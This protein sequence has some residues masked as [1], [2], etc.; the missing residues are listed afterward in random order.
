MVKQP[1]SRAP[2]FSWSDSSEDSW[3]YGTKKDAPFPPACR[4]PLLQDVPLMWLSFRGTKRMS[5]WTSEVDCE[6]G[7]KLEQELL[8]LSQHH[9]WNTG[10]RQTNTHKHTHTRHGFF[11]I[12]NFTVHPIRSSPHTCLPPSLFLSPITSTKTTPSLSLCTFMTYFPL[13]SPLSLCSPEE[14]DE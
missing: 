12:S 6:E 10:L 7:K 2:Q 9:K 14:I 3:L 4:S 5:E 1:L 13:R 11:I 8:L